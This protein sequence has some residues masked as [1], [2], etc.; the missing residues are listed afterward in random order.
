[1]EARATT[2]A[3]GDQNLPAVSGGEK[4]GDA[5]DSGSE[6]VVIPLLATSGM[7]GHPH[8]QAARLA[9]RFIR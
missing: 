1:M 4:A 8:S 3:L 7:H 6:V 9:P 5:V 2:A